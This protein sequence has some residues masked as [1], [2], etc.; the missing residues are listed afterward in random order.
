VGEVL[1]ERLGVVLRDA[2]PGVDAR[3]LP[4]ARRERADV[5]GRILRMQVG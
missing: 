3:M 2:A 4:A 5:R 1:P